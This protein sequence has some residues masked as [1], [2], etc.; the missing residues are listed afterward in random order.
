[1]PEDLLGTDIQWPDLNIGRFRERRPVD[2][3]ATRAFIARLADRDGKPLSDAELDARAA[4]ASAPRDPAA[5]RAVVKGHRIDESI[6]WERRTGADTSIRYTN[7]LV[8]LVNMPGFDFD[9]RVRFELIDGEDGP[10]LAPS[11]V[12]VIV[13]PDAVGTHRPGAFAE[14]GIAPAI[15]EAARVL[16]M[17]VTRDAEGYPLDFERATSAD[18]E[19]LFPRSKTPRAARRSSR[20]VDEEARQV[21]AKYLELC[22][23]A[24]NPPAAYASKIART[25]SWD[26]RGRRAEDL[27]RKRIARAQTMRLLP[28]AIA[29]GSKRRQLR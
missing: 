27:V 12:A 17:R 23:D 5:Q 28:K 16:T 20:K 7:G 3:A 22:D 4:R 9:F 10:V 2:F 26:E 11:A 8:E 18:V 13:R 14:A 25:M 24:G 19:W 29:R 21:A 1:M 15:K 6:V